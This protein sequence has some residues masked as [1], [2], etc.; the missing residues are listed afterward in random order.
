MISVETFVLTC[1]LR[2]APG[3]LSNLD[4]KKNLDWCNILTRLEALSTNN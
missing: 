2:I 3:Q 1:I 4:L